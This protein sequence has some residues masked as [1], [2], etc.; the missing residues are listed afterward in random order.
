MVR[1]TIGALMM[2]AV[3]GGLAYGSAQTHYENKERELRELAMNACIKLGPP[4]EQSN[5]EALQVQLDLCDF[6]HPR[7]VQWRPSH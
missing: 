7:T 4:S 1:C 3:V 6:A 5:T 2:S